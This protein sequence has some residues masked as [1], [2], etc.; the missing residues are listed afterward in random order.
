MTQRDIDFFVQGQLDA[1]PLASVLKEAFLSCGTLIRPP[2]GCAA[3]YFFP[4]PWHVW[5]ED[6]GCLK[7][8]THNYIQIRSFCLWRHFNESFD[9]LA[10]PSEFWKEAIKGNYIKTMGLPNQASCVI[11][12][13]N[14]TLPPSSS[15]STGKGSR[16]MQ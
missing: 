11:L 15:L 9:E 12:T 13:K 4:M 7:R 6:K 1:P 3:T 2:R 8:L 14:D 5:A 10:R 16:R